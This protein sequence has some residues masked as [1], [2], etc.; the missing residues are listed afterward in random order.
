MGGQAGNDDT[1]EKAAK[2]ILEV[3][4]VVRHG[5]LALGATEGGR[6]ERECESE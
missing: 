6:G 4:H 1:N 2:H 5:R 3:I